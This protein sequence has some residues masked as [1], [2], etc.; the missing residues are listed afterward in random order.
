MFVAARANVIPHAALQLDRD[1]AGPAMEVRAILG[2]NG[3]EA[4]RDVVNNR[5]LSVSW[6]SQADQS[7][8]A[9]VR[10]LK[11]FIPLIGH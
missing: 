10:A 7:S 6:L 3:F 9:A 1:I 2:L 8:L 4:I 5:R 11:R